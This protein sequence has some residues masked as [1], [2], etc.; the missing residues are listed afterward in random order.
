MPFWKKNA[1]QKKIEVEYFTEPYLGKLTETEAKFILDH[2]EKQLKDTLETNILI[3]ART[4]TLLTVNVSF[5]I[6]LVG[7]AINKW[8]KTPSSNEVIWTACFGLLYLFVLALLLSRN[9]QPQKYITL[10]ARP[11]SFFVDG[12]YKI[13]EKDRLKYIYANEIQSYQV[14][15][16]E[17]HIINEKRWKLFN[18]CLKWIVAT[19]MV[20]A[21]L[22]IITS[23]IF[24]LHYS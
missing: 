12:F 14:R 20:F 2:A 6:A 19:P 3:V 9:I 22:Y 1:T 13:D 15:I 21:A 23:Y 16:K 5:M 18:L 10:G 4:T 24:N 7:F 8:E 17:N 11:K